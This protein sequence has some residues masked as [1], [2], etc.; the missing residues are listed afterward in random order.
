MTYTFQSM[1]HFEE[2]NQWH[3][4]LEKESLTLIQCKEYNQ[5]HFWPSFK[6]IETNLL[7]FII[8]RLIQNIT[9]I[10]TNNASA[11]KH[12]EVIKTTKVWS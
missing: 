1:R 11:R 2:L 3:S 8:F 12:K 7:I 5:H 6:I 4:Y 10:I 9:E